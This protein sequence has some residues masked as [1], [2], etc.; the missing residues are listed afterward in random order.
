[1]SINDMPSNVSSHVPVSMTKPIE[2]KSESQQKCYAIK[3]RLLQAKSILRGYMLCAT[4]R[5][6]CSGCSN[7]ASKQRL[8]S[9]LEQEM[10]Q[11]SIE[12]DQLAPLLIYRTQPLSLKAFRK[13]L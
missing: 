12:N 9:L 7:E 13:L 2:I 8:V 1:M 4:N 10:L 3:C 6:V 5:N 11:L